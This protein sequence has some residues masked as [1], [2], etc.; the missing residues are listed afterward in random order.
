[1]NN[2]SPCTKNR[3]TIFTAFDPLFGNRKGYNTLNQSQYLLYDKD[4]CAKIR[5]K[6]VNWNNSNCTET[7]VSTDE[8]LLYL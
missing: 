2:N 1:M 8:G 3:N 6:T 7:I 4:F 5:N